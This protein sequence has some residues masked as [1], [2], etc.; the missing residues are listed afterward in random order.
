MPAQARAL[1]LSQDDD[2]LLIE[3]D[4]SLLEFE[5]LLLLDQ[6]KRLLFGTIEYVD[7]ISHQLTVLTS[8]L[9]LFSC[10]AMMLGTR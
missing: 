3:L 4:R 9:L 2:V 5:T 6:K 10:E 1:A 8:D 7:I